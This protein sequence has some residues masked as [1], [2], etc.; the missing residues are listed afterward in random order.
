MVAEPGWRYS[1]SMGPREGTDLCPA[2]H[3]LWL[4]ISGTLAGK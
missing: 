3:S 2:E 4:M 1:E